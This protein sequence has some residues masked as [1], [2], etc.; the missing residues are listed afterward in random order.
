[1]AFRGVEQPDHGASTDVVRPQH[2]RSAQGVGVRQRSL[3]VRYFD[4]HGDVATDEF[5]RL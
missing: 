5:R 1:M 2:A 4:I 3:Y